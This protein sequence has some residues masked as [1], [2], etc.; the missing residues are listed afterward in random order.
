MGNETARSLVRSLILHPNIVV[1]NPNLFLDELARTSEPTDFC[2]EI[3]ARTQTVKENGLECHM[4][5]RRLIRN[6][7][8]R[9]FVPNLRAMA[10][11]LLGKTAL[12]YSSDGLMAD[13]YHHPE[14][15]E[16]L[17]KSACQ[18]SLLARYDAVDELCHLKT[19]RPVLVIP[20]FERDPMVLNWE[21]KNAIYQ[22]MRGESYVTISRAEYIGA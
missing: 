11:R 6:S 19:A 5:L 12:V 20:G 3:N 8:T 2:T 14:L 4:L 17:G 1:P 15:V 16:I 18:F 13:L 10:G 7:G 21:E 22:R 9:G